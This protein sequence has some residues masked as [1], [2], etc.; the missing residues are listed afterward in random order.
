LP[1]KLGD[2]SKS[3]NICEEFTL[4]KVP[5]VI[6]RDQII[7]KDMRKLLITLGMANIKFN[8]EKKRDRTTILE[9]IKLIKVASMSLQLIISF[10]CSGNDT[11]DNK[12]AKLKNKLSVKKYKHFSDLYVDQLLYLINFQMWHIYL[13]PYFSKT[14]FQEEDQKLLAMAALKFVEFSTFTINITYQNQHSIRLIEDMELFDLMA[15]LTITSSKSCKP[16]LEVVF[17]CNQKNFLNKFKKKIRPL[18]HNPH[19]TEPGNHLR[20]Y[21]DLRK[22]F[23]KHAP[24]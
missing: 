4:V 8:Q 16:N 13:Q 22:G 9:L 10:L 17:K 18:C 7:L 21:R 15:N 11:D 20:N 1:L 2:Q 6:V 23:T 24:A 14:A 5:N 12:N 3:N 19:Q